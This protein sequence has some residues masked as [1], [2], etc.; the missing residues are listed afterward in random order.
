MCQTEDIQIAILSPPQ[1][2]DKRQQIF[3]CNK[4]LLIV[5]QRSWFAMFQPNEM[6]KKN[7]TSYP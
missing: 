7:Q 5:R 6:L 2:I 1:E 3:N 4:L